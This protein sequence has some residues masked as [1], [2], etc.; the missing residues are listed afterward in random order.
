MPPSTN[1][2]FITEQFKGLESTSQVQVMPD[3]GEDWTCLPLFKGMSESAMKLFQGAMEEVIYTAGETMITQGDSSED[4]FVLESGTMRVTVTSG[5]TKIFERTFQSP[6]LFGEMALITREPRSATITAETKCR[7]LRIDKTTVQELFRREA[8][9][10]VFLTRLVGERL[11]EASGIRRVGKYEVL[12]RLGSG[13]V[14]TVFEG[15]HP[16]LGTPVALKMLSHALVFDEG[17]ADH[18]A[19]EGRRTASLTHDN[20]V[21]VMDTEEA[22]GT[23]FI[24]ME[25]L[26]GDLLEEAIYSSQRMGWKTIRRILIEALDALAYAHG[27]GFVH[28]DI[29]PENIFLRTDGK[30]KIMDF[31]IATQSGGAQK[32]SDRIIGT[33]YYISPEQVLSRQLDGR[34]DLYSLGITAYEMC[35]QQLP[36]DAET[37]NEL[38]RKHIQTRMPDPRDISPDIPDDLRTFIL[39]ACKKS[40]KKRF[41]GCGEARDFLK[42][43]A[44]VPVLDVFAMSSLSVT[45]HT[46]RRSTVE[47]IMSRAV[48]ELKSLS[49]VAFFEAHRAAGP[50]AAFVQ[51]LPPDLAAELPP[52]TPGE[53]DT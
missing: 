48:A 16:E 10:A 11:L 17:F 44:E 12:G 43:A 24:V 40:A 32:D 47:Q 33:P 8:G 6:Y 25:K 34:A 52:A 53:Q 22:Y 26:T 9:T 20:I 38:F 42:A 2:G 4:M 46:S 18:F 30:V 1:P 21:A 27:E 19:E 31:G 3:E 35:C 23:H 14:A 15:R 51:P 5:E 45:Y 13:G 41:E 28:R 29:K 7:C 36:F 50:S 37:V 49:G 39:R